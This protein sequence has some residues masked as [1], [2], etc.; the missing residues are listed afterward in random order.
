MNP[1][2]NEGLKQFEIVEIDDTLAERIRIEFR[3]EAFD[4]LRFREVGI[5]FA[6]MEGENIAGFI[7]L[8]WKEFPYTFEEPP[9]EAYIDI[10][11]VRPEYR[12]QGIAKKLID[13]C[14]SVA[15]T[16]NCYQLRSWSS[17]DKTEAIAMWKKYNF[18]MNPQTIV[19]G[20]T[21]ENVN[22]YFVTKPIE[23]EENGEK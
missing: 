19:S 23:G 20:R 6:S 18:G 22:G 21:G 10:L 9:K 16:E 13:K 12:R 8:T 1:E 7:S 11:E 17:E 2:Q 15:R 3:Q 4:H 14:E 5:S